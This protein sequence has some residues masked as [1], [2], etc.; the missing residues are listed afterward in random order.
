MNQEF[1][2]LWGLGK[3]QYIFHMYILILQQRSFPDRNLVH[4]RA[5]SAYITGNMYMD[6]G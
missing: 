4:A 5:M 6:G 1:N 2:V 3:T